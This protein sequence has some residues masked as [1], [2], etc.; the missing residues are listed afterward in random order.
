MAPSEVMM[1]YFV[2]RGIQKGRFRRFQKC[3]MW[4]QFVEVR[5]ATV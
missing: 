2:V 1:T 5:I 3:E 4:V